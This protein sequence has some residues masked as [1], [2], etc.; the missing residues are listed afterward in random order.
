MMKTR[1]I[2]DP[3][4][5]ESSW[6]QQYARLA[7]E[8]AR[9]LP[10]TRGV[11]VEIG[12]GKGQLTIPLAKRVPGYRII[13]L[14][15]Y[16]GPYKGNQTEL[17]STIASN[18]MKRRIKVVVSDYTAWLTSQPDAKHDGIVS[19]EFLPEITSKGMGSFFAQCFRILKTGGVT[20]HSFLS[21]QPRNDRQRR[22]IEADSDPRWTK[23][24]PPEWFSPRRRLVLDHLK[25]AGFRKFR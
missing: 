9:M 17:S 3:K 4:D 18:G 25:V 2:S 13:A 8:F 15:R 14:D 20:I 24:P 6:D 22:L 19:S 16:R 7:K 21:P 12:C 10:K 5:L 23:T 1:P 11:L